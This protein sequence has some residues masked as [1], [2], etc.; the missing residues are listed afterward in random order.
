MQI[1]RKLSLIPILFFKTMYMTY[2]T[3]SCKVGHYKEPQT[4][5]L[6]YQTRN[7]YL[8]LCTT[9][10]MP[11]NHVHFTLAGIWLRL[12]HRSVGSLNHIDNRWFDI[13][14]SSSL[15]R[16]SMSRSWSSSSNCSTDH[17][18][19]SNN[20]TGSNSTDWKQLKSSTDF[21]LMFGH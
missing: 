5:S 18:N 12:K 4:L 19:T 14:L 17:E 6:E 10:C 11:C 21:S 1:S 3:C 15:M 13:H 9:T 7:Y 16:Q 2:I 8:R 20:L